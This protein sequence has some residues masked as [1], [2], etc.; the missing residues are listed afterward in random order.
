MESN[1]VVIYSFQI[2][3]GRDEDFMLAWTILTGLIYQ[4][5][6]SLGSRLHKLNEREY[7]AYAVWPDRQTFE[8]EDNNLPKIAIKYRE[9]MRDAC[10]NIESKYEMQMVVDLV[11]KEPFKN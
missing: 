9:E 2:H 4:Y 3:E 10:S 11:R 1:F 7:I 6:G 5:K 8:K